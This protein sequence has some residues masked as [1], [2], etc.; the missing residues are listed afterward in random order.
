MFKPSTYVACYCVEFG[1]TMFILV[2]NFVMF[3]RSRSRTHHTNT[4]HPPLLSG[5]VCRTSV[6]PL[7]D[8]DA[9]PVVV[10]RAASRGSRAPARLGPRSLIRAIVRAVC[11]ALSPASRHHHCACPCGTSPTHCG[12]AGRPCALR[13]P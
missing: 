11:I 5:P 13:S 10:A 4:L 3:S 6:W 2:E 12:S 8:H 1:Q 9:S 7:T